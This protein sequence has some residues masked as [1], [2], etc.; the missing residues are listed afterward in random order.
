M[1][2]LCNSI[3]SDFEKIKKQS[4]SILHITLPILAVIVFTVYYSYTHWTPASKAGGFLEMA[5]LLLPA[6]IGVVSAMAV[7]QESSAGSF[8]HMLTS[9]IKIIPFLSKLIVTLLLGLGAILILTCGFSTT[10]KYILHQNPFGFSYY[11]YAAFILF[12]SSIFIYVL[13]FVISF[14]FGGS[15]SIGLGIFET[16]L[17][18]LFNTGLGDGKW[19]FV[20]CTWGMRFIMNLNRFM[21]KS[22]SFSRGI[23]E[24]Y[25]GI[26]FCTLGTIVITILACS[27]FLNWEGRKSE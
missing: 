22:S 19:E 24:L 23:S 15:A 11:L 1:G 13:H 2:F 18:A 7:D 4:I 14:K 5:A 20:P 9:N 10:F 25:L 16:L 12:L 21:V 3:K 6:L 17:A 8:Q 26:L 27:W